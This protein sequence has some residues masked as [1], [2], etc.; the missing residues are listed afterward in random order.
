M[1]LIVDVY[2]ARMNMPILNREFNDA[3]RNVSSTEAQA[4]ALPLCTEV[5]ATNSTGV[6][7]KGQ[8]R[9]HKGS[10]ADMIINNGIY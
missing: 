6:E 3:M 7:I 5:G 8:L 9:V 2:K 1:I 4:L 10:E